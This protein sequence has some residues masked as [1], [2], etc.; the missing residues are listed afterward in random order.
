MRPILFWLCAALC[1]NHKFAA[2]QANDA[3]IVWRPFIEKMIVNGRSVSVE[4]AVVKVDVN[5]IAKQL[6]A[7]WHNHE[8][9]V[10][11]DR[12]GEWLIVSRIFQGQLESAQIRPIS[13]DSSELLKHKTPLASGANPAAIAD[14]LPVWITPEFSVAFVT[15]SI[16]QGQRANTYLLATSLSPEAALNRLVDRLKATGFMPHPTANRSFNDQ[17][18]SQGLQVVMASSNGAHATLQAMTTH[19]RTSVLVLYKR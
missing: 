4:R 10:K 9:P 11:V 5:Q 12:S 3:L 1:W 13:P 2:A 15:Q 6:Q 17:S 8:F 19:A 18:P 16:D 7:Q 14:P